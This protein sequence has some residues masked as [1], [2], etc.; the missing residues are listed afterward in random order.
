MRRAW[1]SA[2]LVIDSMSP[3]FIGGHSRLQELIPLL[4]R[5]SE[6]AGFNTD[7]LIVYLDDL[8]YSNRYDIRD[9]FKFKA[10]L[11]RAGDPL[12][13][14][15]TA[16]SQL[17]HGP[18]AQSIIWLAKTL[19]DSEATQVIWVYAHEFRHFMQDR[20]AVDL[21]PLQR[22]LMDRHT[23]EK[24]SGLGTQLEKPAELD[25]E[26]F[27]KKTVKAIIGEQA[28]C[29]YLA[30]CRKSPKGDAYF[31]RFSE[32]ELLAAERIDI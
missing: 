15:P 11:W 8:D 6:L 22:F 20:G 2:A 29:S 24:F 14:V 1:V 26:L 4:Q 7:G 5:A 19:L 25:S 16:L 13:R 31:R 32:L 30:E 28:L 12:D 23:I 17:M 3:K 10:F 27:A 21:M 18:D 9:D